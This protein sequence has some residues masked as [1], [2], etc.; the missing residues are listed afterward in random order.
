MSILSVSHLKLPTYTFTQI[1]AFFFLTFSAATCFSA[2]V[3]P[4]PYLQDQCY[5][6]F[7]AQTHP[8][9][10]RKLITQ[11]SPVWICL[12]LL[13]VGFL[14]LTPALRGLLCI[15]IVILT[16]MLLYEQRRNLT[17]CSKEN[18]WPLTGLVSLLIQSRL[19]ATCV[20][21]TTSR[22]LQQNRD[23]VLLD[24]GPPQK[25]LGRVQSV[26][27]QLQ[28]PGAASEE[29]N[30]PRASRHSDHP[31]HPPGLHPDVD[32]LQRDGSSGR[33]L[34]RVHP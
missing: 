9:I 24:C 20:S 14:C 21:F 4:P 18:R 33:L 34:S 11:C 22:R 8:V 2:E 26:L 5:W 6:L 30:G 25:G 15:V 12:V 28:V 1:L 31:R 23:R 16:A 32:A 10:I 19:G 13:F 7:I 17:C 29:G 27:P 3:A